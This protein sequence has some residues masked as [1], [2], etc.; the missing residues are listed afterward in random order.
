MG[1]SC[2]AMLRSV[3]Q[4]F[5][6][7]TRAKATKAKATKADA[8]VEVPVRLHG[9]DGRYA[10]SLYSVAVRKG[11]VDAVEADL[12]A[13]RG[14]LGSS[15]AL[16]ELVANPSIP[17]KAKVES[18]DALNAKSGFADPTKNLLAL[19]AENNRLS[20][21]ENIADKYDEMLRASR[22]QIFAEVTVAEEL[23]KAQTSSLEKSLGAFLSKGQSLTMSVKT[24]ASILGG[25]VVE[26]G[27]KHVDLSI[28]SRINKY[29]NE[30]NRGV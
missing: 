16:S 18:I 27:D 24:D 8:P 1:L 10:T 13:L 3:A 26:I 30:L 2:S 14:S 15:K 21:L 17:K 9:L 20:E 25:L 12:I 23:T 19:M 22:G 5:P 6:K 28:I 29:Q 11:A 7:G 4:R